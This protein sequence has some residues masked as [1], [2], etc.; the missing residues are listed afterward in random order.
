MRSYSTL[1]IGYHLHHNTSQWVDTDGN[2]ATHTNWV[3]GTP[4]NFD[5]LGEWC[6]ELRNFGQTNPEKAARFVEAPFVPGWNDATCHPSYKRNYIC[7]RAVDGSTDAKECTVEPLWQ[8]SG[9]KMLYP[10][11]MS[12]MVLFFYL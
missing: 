12:I 3:L 8:Y 1:W 11:I 6:A 7:Q 4:D 5:N 9:S 2:A 10:S